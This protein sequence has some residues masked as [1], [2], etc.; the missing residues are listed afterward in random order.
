MG[1]GPTVR[2]VGWSAAAGNPQRIASMPA[3]AARLALKS[4]GLRLGDVHV[5]EINEAFAAVPLVSTIVLANGDAKETNRLRELTN[6]NGGSIAIGHPTGATAARMV[7]TAASELT[8]RGGGIGLVTICGGIG[9]AESVVISVDDA[10]AATT[11]NR[12]D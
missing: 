8:G 7:M 3:I 2:I 5:I 11:T 6:V 12:A 9:E 1:D 10:H 4:A